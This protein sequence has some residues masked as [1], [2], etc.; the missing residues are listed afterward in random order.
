[1][2]TWKPKCGKNHGSPQT[3]E[4][5]MRE[6]YNDE[7]IEAMT[8]CASTSPHGGYNGGNDLFLSLSHSHYAV[9]LCTLITTQNVQQQQ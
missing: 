2:F 8:S 3:A 6:D 7:S 4:Y 9:T 1:M 5:T